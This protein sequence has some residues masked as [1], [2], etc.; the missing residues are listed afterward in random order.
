M[1][2]AVRYVLA[3]QAD[4]GPVDGLIA[5]AFDPI[6]AGLRDVDDDVRAVAA[7]ALYPIANSLVSFV[8]RPL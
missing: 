8:S 3:V 1:L 5:M 2:L 4:R 7:E 6:A